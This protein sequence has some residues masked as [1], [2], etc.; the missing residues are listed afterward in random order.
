MCLSRRRGHAWHQSHEFAKLAQK[1]G[2]KTLLTTFPQPSRNM[3][4]QHQFKPN[5]LLC[6]E[7]KLILH[8][9]DELQ[10][11]GVAAFLTK[12]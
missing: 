11:E 8:Q 10:E 5:R 3:L 7:A 1:K 12:N 4:P 9:E 2:K 6:S